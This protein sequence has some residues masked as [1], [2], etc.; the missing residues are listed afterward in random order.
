VM[1]GST[2]AAFA[3]RI[4]AV[5]MNITRLAIAPAYVYEAPRRLKHNTEVRQDGD[6]ASH[7]M[8]IM[9]FG[10]DAATRGRGLGCKD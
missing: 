10:G 1:V 4:M 8:V 7:R 3:E 6:T 2:A 9:R 5:R